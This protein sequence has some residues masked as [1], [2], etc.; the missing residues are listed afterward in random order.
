MQTD[1]QELGN[2]VAN[3]ILEIG[4]FVQKPEFQ[5]LLFELRTVPAERR[6]EFVETVLLNDNELAHRGIEIPSGM[7]LQRSYFADN[8][9][10]LFCLTKKLSQ[11]QWKVTIT[12]DA[13]GQ[14]GSLPLAYPPEQGQ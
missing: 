3:G 6:V 12:F 10:T 2:E 9:P 14:A 11:K 1:P 13:E 4:K 5:R 7:V 8:R